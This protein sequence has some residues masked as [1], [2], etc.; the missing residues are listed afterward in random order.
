MGARE[1][2]GMSAAITRDETE[3]PWLKAQAR[4]TPQATALVCEEGTFSYA[5]LAGGAEAVARR[6]TAAGFARGQRLALLATPSRRYVELVHAAQH[7]GL[8]LVPLNERLTVPDLACQLEHAAPA[9]LLHYET[10]AAAARKLTVHIPALRPLHL[11][12]ALA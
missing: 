12:E 6:L 7:A 3:L 11:G 4:K 9:W 10:Q 5:E 2:L 8:V 1:P